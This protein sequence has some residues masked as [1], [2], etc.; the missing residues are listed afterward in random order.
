TG[1][2]VWGLRADEAYM[3]WPLDEYRL[4]AQVWPGI[5]GVFEGGDRVFNCLIDGATGTVS[6]TTG[7][8]FA[9]FAYGDGQADEP[10]GMRVLPSGVPFGTG[11]L[12]PDVA[13]SLPY[14]EVDPET[15]SGFR[16][17]QEADGLILITAQDGTLIGLP[18]VGPG[19]S[20]AHRSTPQPESVVY[21]EVAWT[22]VGLDEPSW[23]LSGHAIDDERLYLAYETGK[24]DPGIVRALDLE[25]GTELWS[26]VLDVTS[27]VMTVSDELLLFGGLVLPTGQTEAVVALHAETGQ[28]VWRAE[29]SGRVASMIV[30]GDR[31]LVL[32]Q[33]NMLNAITLES[34][35]SISITNVGGRSKP[36]GSPISLGD[37]RLAVIDDMLVAVLADG[38]LAGIDLDSGEGKWWALRDTPGQT[39]IV[40]VDGVLIVFAR[41]EPRIP[42]YGTPEPATPVASPIAMASPVIALCSH[43][44]QL[45][46]PSAT[47]DGSELQPGETMITR[48]DPATGVTI[49]NAKSDHVYNLEFKSD[50]GILSVVIGRDAW[51]ADRS[52]MA[53]CATDP[54][55]GRVN[56][57]ERLA[58][59]VQQPYRLGST[60]PTDGQ[61]YDIVGGTDGANGWISLPAEFDPSVP[62][63]TIVVD[64]MFVEGTEMFLVH[65]NAFYIALEG[66][67]VSKVVFS[68]D[69]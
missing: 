31:L 56:A 1:A 41:G 61:V 67:S 4:V 12:D 35:Q 36:A 19:R 66:G 15:F 49:W 57:V 40:V 22:A 58:D 48:L 54:E 60:S 44:V 21:A 47:I 55:R 2:S 68:G 8:E 30:I 53:L 3:A 43:A 59:V 32:T 29:I 38:S 23:W 10:W 9:T 63:P 13:K 17:V 46:L 34:G 28:E 45:A 37:R 39:E 65:E 52:D 26:V 20:P 11:H 25:T 6:E 14:F 64:E 24:P 69:A 16:W 42:E 7:A 51:P 62:G 27:R 5:S 18:L 33:S 50:A